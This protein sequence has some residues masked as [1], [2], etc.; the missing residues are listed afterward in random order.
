MLLPCTGQLSKSIGSN[1]PSRV[2]GMH[3]A[4]L[5]VFVNGYCLMVSLFWYAGSAFVLP[6]LL[7]VFVGAVRQFV[8]FVICLVLAFSTSVQISFAN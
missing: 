3:C 6:Y 7:M 2:F 5:V 8:A 1:P 4:C